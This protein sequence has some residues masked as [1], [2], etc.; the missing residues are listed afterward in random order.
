MLPATWWECWGVLCK[1]L[2]LMFQG[3]FQLTRFCDPVN[4]CEAAEV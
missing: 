1:E 3:H 4:S 2:G